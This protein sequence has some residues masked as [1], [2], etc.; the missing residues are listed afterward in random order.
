MS[1]F[2]AQNITHSATSVAA[3][4]FNQRDHRLTVARANDRVAFP[5]PHLLASLNV[6]WTITNGAAICNLPASVTPA[7]VAFTPGLLAAQALVQLAPIGLVGINMLVHRFMADGQLV[8]NL[9]GA[10]LNAQVERHLRPHP[11]LHPLGIA[12]ALR[13]LLGLFTG[14]LGSVAALPV[15]TFNRSSCSQLSSTRLLRSCYC[16][17]NSNCR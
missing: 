6:C 3:L 16:C 15:A 8:G 12:A 5:M 1:G 7:Q 17:H 14:L 11:R 4:A 2:K 9:F 13:T 10:P